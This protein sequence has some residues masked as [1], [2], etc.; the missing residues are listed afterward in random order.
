MFFEIYF[1]LLHSLVT[2][3]SK[4]GNSLE[5]SYLLSMHA[6]ST[7]LN[8]DALPGFDYGLFENEKMPP[9]LS[10]KR[11]FCLFEKA[12]AFSEKA[13]AWERCLSLIEI[14]IRE[15]RLIDGNHELLRKYLLKQIDLLDR[16]SNSTRLPPSLFMVSYHGDEFQEEV[17]NKM[18]V[19]HRPRGE[20]M[21]DFGSLQR[22]D[23]PDAILL[24]QNQ[25]PSEF[26]IDNQKFVKIVRVKPLYD[27]NH[28]KK[29]LS[30]HCSNKT[31]MGF[32]ISEEWDSMND[33][34]NLFEYRIC[35]RKNSSIDNEFLDLWVTKYYVVTDIPL[36][37]YVHKAD[38]IEITSECLNPIEVATEELEER[39]S[40]LV[41]GI[42]EMEDIDDCE[43]K[44]A[45]QKITMELSGTVDAAV[46]GGISRYDSFLSHDYRWENP[47][48]DID[49]IGSGK[50]VN[51]I[52]MEFKNA[53][54]LLITTIGRAVKIHQRKV[55]NDMRA[56]HEHLERLYT[57]VIIPKKRKYSL[58]VDP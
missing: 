28:G 2:I 17:R 41:R 19:Y 11:R 53:F 48:I 16:L 37:T 55:S 35:T 57:D 26:T 7:K 8:D 58:K 9:I 47:S 5:A 24:K 50:D 12:I 20:T 44:F 40:I 33:S 23:H 39:A 30:I 45:S 43:D 6:K 51:T 15:V 38:V 21:L 4:N 42:K 22:N 10:W 52:L 25:M 27:F 14:I 36:P 46:N 34:T 49:I 29:D 54:Q 3:Y 31:N 13:F 18:F 1:S 32:L 56:L